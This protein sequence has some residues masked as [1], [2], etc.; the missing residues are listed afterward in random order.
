MQV[1]VG[2]GRRQARPRTRW[3]DDLA[4]FFQERGGLDWFIVAQ[5]QKDWQQ[6]EEEFVEQAASI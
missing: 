5:N 3:S 4:S 1:E 6:Y 2:H